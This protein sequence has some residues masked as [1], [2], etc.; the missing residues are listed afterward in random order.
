MNLIKIYIILMK[1]KTYKEH[2]ELF[3]EGAI[4]QVKMP[5]IWI[6][7]Y[8]AAKQGEYNVWLP[9]KI[10]EIKSSDTEFPIIIVRLRASHK[11]HT[12][13]MENLWIAPSQVEQGI[14]IK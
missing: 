1:Y 8:E 9:A 12:V 13:S 7:A 2:P 6:G 10:K 5:S 4:C 11:Y 3:I 14:K